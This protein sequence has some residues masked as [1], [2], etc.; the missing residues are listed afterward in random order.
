MKLQMGELVG[1]VEPWISRFPALEKS[2][3]LVKSKGRVRGQEMK[4]HEG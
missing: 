2:T 1:E 4:K 3:C